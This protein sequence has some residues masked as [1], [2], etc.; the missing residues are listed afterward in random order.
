MI[1]DSM[2]NIVSYWLHVLQVLVVN[3]VQ[4]IMRL[5]ALS[6]TGIVLASVNNTMKEPTVR[7]EP[8]VLWEHQELAVEME[9]HLLVH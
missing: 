4:V 2:A 3:S 9:E 7:Q 6:M 1:Q 5:L 8:H